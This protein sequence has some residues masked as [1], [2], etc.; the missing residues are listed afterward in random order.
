MSCTHTA[1]LLQETF[2]ANLAKYDQVY[3]AYFDVS[4]AFDRV[5]VDGLF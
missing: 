4:K 5:W 2:A 1:V 3:V